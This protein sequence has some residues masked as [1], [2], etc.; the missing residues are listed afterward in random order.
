[1]KKSI[2]LAIFA[3]LLA[4]SPAGIAGAVPP[5]EDVAK[6]HGVAITDERFNF[7]ATSDPGGTNAQ[8]KLRFASTLTFM[9][10]KG[11]FPV[12]A[13]VTCLNVFSANQAVIGGVVTK[14]DHPVFQVGDGILFIVEDDGKP[15]GGIDQ[16]RIDPVTV[17]VTCPAITLAGFL[18]QKGDI[19]V[20]NA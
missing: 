15:G 7:S 11:P 16:L 17:P 19:I 5:P 4:V 8:G 12:V 14:A 9:G 10:E 2:A 6:G 1:M 18:I 20:E 3:T 13:E